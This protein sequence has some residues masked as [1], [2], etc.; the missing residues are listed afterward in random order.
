[1]ANFIGQFLVVHL[2]HFLWH[3]SFS[4]FDLKH[5]Q[6]AMPPMIILFDQNSCM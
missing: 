4:I 1:L 2:V 3:I 5:V 6:C